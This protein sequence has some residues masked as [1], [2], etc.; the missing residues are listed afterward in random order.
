MCCAARIFSAFC[1]RSSKPHARW[2]ARISFCLGSAFPVSVRAPNILRPTLRPRRNLKKLSA[3]LEQI[4]TEHPGKRLEVWTQ[5]EARFGQQ[6]TTS[7]IWGDRGKRMRAVRQTNYKWVYLFAAVC[8][9]T[10]R[11]HEW[12]MPYVNTAHMNIFMET[13]GQA[14]D[15]DVHAA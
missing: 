14:L 7:R 6:G 12:L 8:P 3:R 5:D 11:T 10:G 9:Q 4:R 2:V 1:S 13:F 15:S